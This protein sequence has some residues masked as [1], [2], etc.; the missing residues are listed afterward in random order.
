MEESH[1]AQDRLL[2]LLDVFRDYTETGRVANQIRDKLSAK[3][4][5]HSATLANAS[6]QA[7]KT[8]KQATIAASNKAQ[9]IATQPA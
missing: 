1:V 7:T 2:E 4:A 3:L 9:P 5:Y 6:Q 8:L